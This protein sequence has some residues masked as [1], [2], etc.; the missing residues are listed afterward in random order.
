[1]ALGFPDGDGDAARSVAG[2]VGGVRGGGK[3]ALLD[4]ADCAVM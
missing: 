2:G 3:R 4:P 1:M